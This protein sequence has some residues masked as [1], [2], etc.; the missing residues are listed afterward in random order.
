MKIILLISTLLFSLNAYSQSI[1]KNYQEMTQSEKDLLVNAFYQLRTGSDLI[2]DL[3]E[4]HADNFGI[5][6]SP[7]PI[8]FNLPNN[9]ERDV[10]LA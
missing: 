3:A 8:H 1:R 10:F 5:I 2:G 4:F 6:D 7:T 9:P